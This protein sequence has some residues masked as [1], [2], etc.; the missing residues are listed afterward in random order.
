M[1][2]IK[3]F[4]LFVFFGIGG[5]AGKMG[6]ITSHIH[7]SQAQLCRDFLENFDRLVARVDGQ[8]IQAV[9]VPHFPGFRVNRFLASFQSQLLDEIALRQWLQTMA[10]LAVTGRQLEYQNL[11]ALLQNSLLKIVSVKPSIS[12][13]LQTCATVSVDNVI[14]D[15][16]LQRQLRANISVPDNYSL[17][18]RIMGG[19][20]IS[21]LAV[22]YGVRGLHQETA[23]QFQQSFN[24]IPIKGKLSFYGPRFSMP[25]VSSK[26]IGITPRTDPKNALAMPVFTPSQWQTLWEKHAPILA[27]DTVSSDD[28]VGSP[29]WLNVNESAIDTNVPMVYQKVSYARIDDQILVQLNYILWFPARSAK[30]KFDIYA[31]RFDGLTWRV[32]LTSDGRA[33]M[34][35]SVHNCGCYHKFYPSKQIQLR[36]N[37]DQGFEPP[38][39]AQYVTSQKQ[40]QRILLRISHATHFITRVLPVN[41]DDIRLDMEY[42]FATYQ[43]LRSLALPREGR[44][45]FFSHQGL[46]LGSERP[47]RWLLWP[48]GVYSP[49]AMRQWGTHAIAFIGRRHFDDPYLI[50]RFFTQAGN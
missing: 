11:S 39:I 1:M 19:Y 18:K 4:C 48:M 7:D 17:T 34:Y 41:V 5:C 15:V 33:L 21:S 44:K 47:E 23:K 9:A 16:A 30:G 40:N 6:I 42:G 20:P 12:E 22:A 27:I 10:Q 2:K 37:I 31:G 29:I 25:M 38:F 45:S 24:E 36:S 46:V 35:D 28:L 43:K 32:T 49:G 13:S 3:L 50:D 8:D 26:T 14:T